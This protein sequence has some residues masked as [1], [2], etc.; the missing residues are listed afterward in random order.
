MSKQQTF[1]TKLL[2][3]NN[4]MIDFERWADKRM[5][6]VEN[7]LKKLYTEYFGVYKEYIEKALYI[8]IYET[9]EN[10]DIEVKRINI[11]EFLS[12]A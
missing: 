7:K 12:L 6:T 9:K 2:D 1:I 10:K 3:E 11:K 4:S 5:Q 8:V